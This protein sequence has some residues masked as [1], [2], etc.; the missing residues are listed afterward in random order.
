[1]A[2]GEIYR[3]QVRLLVRTLPYIAREDCFALKGGTAINLFIRDLPR[4]SVDIDLTYLPDADR[5]TA[6]VA[7]EKALQRITAALQVALPDVRITESRPHSQTTINKLIVRTRHGV[8]IKIEVT[9]VLRGSVFSPSRRT[10]VP[11]VEDEYGFAEITVLHFADLFAGK[12][13]AAL[14]RQHPRDLFD[15]SLLLDNEGIDAELRS[16]I[17]IYLISHDRPPDELL[18]PAEKDIAHEYET[19]F[20]GMTDQPVELHQLIAARHKLSSDLLDNMP[21]H[22]KQFLI[23]FYRQ[24][25]DWALLGLPGVE[26]LPAVGW[27]QKN[28]NK[29]SKA[30]QDALNNSLSA[31]LSSE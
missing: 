4:L 5:Q 7:I 30:R 13:M 3:E 28:L 9:P 1:M 8:Q 20:T 2:F 18:E 22:H 15:V 31:L 29:A 16:A 17:I 26:S 25:P 21:D 12:I 10:V 23:S 27:K 11:R 14:D 6:L 24:E 19:G